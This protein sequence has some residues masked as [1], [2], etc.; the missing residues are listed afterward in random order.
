[1]ISKTKDWEEEEEREGKKK[2]QIYKIFQFVGSV[3]RMK[4]FLLFPSSTLHP[5]SSEQARY[6]ADLTFYT[7]I[8]RSF[9]ALHQRCGPAL[10]KISQEL[11]K[12]MCYIH[13]SGKIA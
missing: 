4:C 5:S 10:D 6:A 12:V 2:K 11:L 7:K 13:F 1:M 3:L 8:S 9:I